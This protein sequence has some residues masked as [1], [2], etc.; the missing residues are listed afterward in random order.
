MFEFIC[1]VRHVMLLRVD[2]EH[3]RAST[4]S[5]VPVIIVGVLDSLLRG[6]FWVS[7][8]LWSTHVP[9]FL[10]FFEEKDKDQLSGVVIP[11]EDVIINTAIDA[12][13][14][15]DT[16]L[17]DFQHLI[18]IE[19]PAIFVGFMSMSMSSWS[20]ILTIRFCHHMRNNDGLGLLG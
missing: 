5:W 2:I 20:W 6:F 4:G 7:C 1:Y 17:Q 3:C 19:I 8:R 12:T 18:Q 9:H 10:Y 15:V 13:T 16:L 14:V 11:H